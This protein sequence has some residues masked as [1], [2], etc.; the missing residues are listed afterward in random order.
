MRTT[1]IVCPCG[2]IIKTFEFDDSRPNMEMTGCCQRCTQLGKF[3]TDPE[4]ERR[5]QLHIA[6]VTALTKSQKGA[7]KK[8]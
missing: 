4:E 5:K 7:R 6:D 1:K 3:W 8:R 2:T